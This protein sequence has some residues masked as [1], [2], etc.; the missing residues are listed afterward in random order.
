MPLLRRIPKTGF[1]N[2]RFARKF[3]WI[4]VGVL[5]N[6]F[7]PGME[8]TPDILRKKG[9]I[10]GGGPVKILGNGEV[11]HSLKV[12]ADSFSKSAREKIEKAGGTTTL[13]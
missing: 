4:N 12:T 8:V 10:K 6:I 2:T 9:F 11:K 5:Q 7:S 13:I 1:R 3:K